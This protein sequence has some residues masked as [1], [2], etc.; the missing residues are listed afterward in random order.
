MQNNFLKFNGAKSQAR[1]KRLPF[2]NNSLKPYLVQIVL[3]SSIVVV[4]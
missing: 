1:H 3:A 2:F 4:V